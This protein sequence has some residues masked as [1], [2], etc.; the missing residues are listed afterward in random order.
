MPKYKVTGQ[1]TS[2]EEHSEII[3]AP[4]HKTAI[5]IAHS[6]GLSKQAELEVTQIDGDQAGEIVTRV[7]GDPYADV[8]SVGFHAE[9]ESR[10]LI[11][12]ISTIAF[13]VFFGMTC[14]SLLSLLVSIF[15][16]AL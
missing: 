13:G 3:D 9:S 16:R 11:A 15:Y 12:P 14:F 6:R 7:K 10:L 5:T 4:S 1:N 2:G 8:S